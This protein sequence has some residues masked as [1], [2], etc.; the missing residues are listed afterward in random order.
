MRKSPLGVQDGV[1]GGLKPPSLKLRER[2]V[3]G[4][5]AGADAH[6]DITP[7]CVPQ[8]SVR[9]K[10]RKELL[11]GFLRNIVKSADEAVITGMSGIKVTSGTP[12]WSPPRASSLQKD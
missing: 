11:G 8:L 7:S 2:R 4:G 5:R 9:G 6:P 1:L 12:L 3:P 10:N